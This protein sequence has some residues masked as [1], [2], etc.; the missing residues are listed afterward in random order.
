MCINLLI[1]YHVWKYAQVP[2]LEFKMIGTTS[3]QYFDSILTATC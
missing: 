2:S 1:D 3:Q